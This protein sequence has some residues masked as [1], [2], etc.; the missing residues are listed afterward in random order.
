MT[1]PLCSLCGF[2][3]ANSEKLTR[4][5][6]TAV[7]FSLVRA[8]DQNLIIGECW[9]HFGFWKSCSHHAFQLIATYVRPVIIVAFGDDLQIFVNN[10]KFRLGFVGR[11]GI[12]SDCVAVWR[13]MTANKESREKHWKKDFHTDLRRNFETVARRS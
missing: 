12:T 3:S 13:A 1:I 11:L 8:I 4:T 10:H 7:L 9:S 6:L 5:I 2:D